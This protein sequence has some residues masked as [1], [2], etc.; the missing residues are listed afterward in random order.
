MNNNKEL[1]GCPI[2][3]IFRILLSDGKWYTIEKDIEESSR[4]RITKDK[5]GNPI[6]FDAYVYRE[7][8]NCKYNQ[9]YLGNINQIK[10]IE[11]DWS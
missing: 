5:D 4:F 8:N 10:L 3:S 9:R 1:W 11:A 2:Y 6:A 7:T